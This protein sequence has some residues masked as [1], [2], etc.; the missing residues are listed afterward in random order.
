MESQ[1]ST[2]S[3]IT[4]FIQSHNDILI[5]SDLEGLNPATQINKITEHLSGSVEGKTN[6]IIYNGDLVDYTTAPNSPPEKIS[7]NADNLCT[8]KLLKLLVNGMESGNAKCMIGNRELNKIKLLALIQIQDNSKWWD[9]GETILEISQ[10]LVSKTSTPENYNAFWKV[11]DFTPFNPFWAGNRDNLKKLWFDTPKKP[12]TL[13]GR[14][15]TIFGVDTTVGTMSAQNNIKFLPMELGIPIEGDSTKSDLAAAIVFTVFARLLDKDLGVNPNKNV[16]GDKFGNLDSYLYKYLD[17]A[18]CATYAEID[19]TILLFAHGGIS[20]EFVTT[21]SSSGIT[22]LNSLNKD[23]WKLISNSPSQV[24]GNNNLFQ[25]ID[26]F[27]TTYK[28]LFNQLYSDSNHLVQYDNNN[29]L[30]PSTTLQILLS[31]CAPAENHPLVKSKQYDT[32]LSPIQVASPMNA[33]LITASNDIPGKQI[34]NIFSH[35]PKGVGYTFGRFV[36]NMYFINTDFSNSLMK[37]RILLGQDI[38]TYNNNYLLLHLLDANR[39]KLDGY[40]NLVY[41]GY[42]KDNLDIKTID[43]FINMSFDVDTIC[44][45]SIDFTKIQNLELTFNDNMPFN[46]LEFS[47]RNCAGTKINCLPTETVSFFNHGNVRINYNNTSLGYKLITKVDSKFKK[48][49]GIFSTI[50][51]QINMFQPQQQLQIGKG[52]GIR[53][54]TRKHYSRKQKTKKVIKKNKRKSVK[55]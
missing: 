38:T 40:L 6:G 21:E 26:S 3:D 23:E 13:I 39:F 28:E 29:L 54:R 27:C 14:F 16:W 24:G 4:S 8:L 48:N 12:S 52:K 32:K 17:M 34:I 22:K 19:N 36:D 44:A 37:D 53:H 55:V 33:N 47:M 20:S 15:D 45:P 9:D 1:T 7:I 5:V 50:S 11:L 49:I 43:D 2:I 31:I 41:S 42:K 10:N 51:N 46:N 18:Y 30:Y 35:I 25:K